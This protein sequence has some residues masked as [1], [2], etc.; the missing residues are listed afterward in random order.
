MTT[1]DRP[2]SRP[3]RAII[4]LPGHGE[5]GR[6][7]SVA[8]VSAASEAGLDRALRRWLDQGYEAKR[9]LEV[10]LELEGPEHDHDDD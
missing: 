1:M 8:K 7:V 2:G 4:Y 5:G 10:P 6:L 3:Y 9:W